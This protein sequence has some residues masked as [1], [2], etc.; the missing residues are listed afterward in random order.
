VRCRAGAHKKRRLGRFVRRLQYGHAQGFQGCVQLSG[1]N[2]V[3]IVDEKPVAFVTA[4]TFPKLLKRPFRS[5]MSSHVKVQDTSGFDFH[6][7]KHIDQ[8]ECRRQ[9]RGS[10]WRSWLWHGYERTSSSAVR[11]LPAS[12]V[13]AACNVESSWAKSEFRSSA[14]VHRRYAPRPKLDCSWPFRQLASASRPGYAV[15]HAVEIS[16]SKT[17]GIPCDA[18]G[19]GC[20]V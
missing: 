7:D 12:S 8:L 18:N 3:T 4:N 20:P 10:R 16:I 5:R 15:G 6:D 9:R 17:G 14:T 1:V 19:L 2:A 13:L 11:D